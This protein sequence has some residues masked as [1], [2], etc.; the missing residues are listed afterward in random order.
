MFH[1]KQLPKSLRPVVAEALDSGLWELQIKSGGKH[2]VR[3]VCTH[4]GRQRVVSTSPRNAWRTAKNL[5]GDLLRHHRLS[6]P[7]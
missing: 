6:H 7:S 3:L 4:C 2:P 1:V 5:R